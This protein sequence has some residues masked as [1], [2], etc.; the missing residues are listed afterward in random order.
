LA[1][2]PWPALALRRIRRPI[3]ARVQVERGLPAHVQPS[4]RAVP[5][6]RVV[7]RAGPWR[8]SGHW[9]SD[10]TRWDRD[11]WDVEIAGGGCYR[12]ARSQGQWEIDAEID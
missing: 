11:E 4:S 2:G 10:A 1:F 3:P 5:V 8:S 7:A 6:G 9:W 12:L